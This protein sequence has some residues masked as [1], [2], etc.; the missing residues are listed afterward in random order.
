M[1]PLGLI[2]S[3]LETIETMSKGV[4]SGFS[5]AGPLFFLRKLR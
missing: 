3:R 5:R 4:D 1:S 2:K